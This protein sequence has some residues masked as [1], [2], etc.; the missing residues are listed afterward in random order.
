M[1]TVVLFLFLWNFRTTFI[2]L[3]AIP[4]SLIAAI[5]VMNYFGISI[6]TMTLG[7]LAIAIGALVDDAI[8]DVENVF[9]RL[10]QNAHSPAPAPVMDV[11]FR[12]SSEIRNSILF[13]T[14]IIVIVFLPL[15]SLGGFEGRMFAPLAFAYIISITASLVVALTV[16]PVLCYFLLGRSKL[17]HDEK[18]SRLVA[19]TKRHYA[20]ILNWTLRHPYKI[21]ATSAA[22]LLV[23]VVMFAF[24]GREFLPPF[25][26]GTLNINANMPP[27][28]SLQESN[29][30][31]NVI[32]TV[33]HEVPE[34]VSTT[35][36]TGRAELDEHA[37]GVNTSEIEVVIKEGDRP[38]AEF[39]EDVRQRLARIPG[40]EAEVGQPISHRIDH[41]LSG[42]RAQIAIKLF[43]PDLATLRTKA[44]EIREQM[45][46]IDG[47][48]DLLVEPQVGVPQVKINL[49]RTQA[50]AVGL[51]AEDLAETVDTAFNGHTASQVLED[52]RTY[53]VLIRF[54]GIAG[55]DRCH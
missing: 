24:M 40:V 26:E 5:L 9:R 34:V 54:D 27:G 50:A 53:D 38:H 25:N 47:V 48:V 45:S 15:F 1:V 32:E 12:A 42:T 44:A 3:T 16:T 31:G 6:N 29:R 14:L 49:N 37:A 22:M 28:T 36:R 30:I 17:I 13:A 8:I 18:D 19:W 10:K 21:I 4:L 46:K 43:G 7:G 23:A 35:R 52:Q 33:L 39:M 2:S 55:I 41:L 51:K 20:G 11:I